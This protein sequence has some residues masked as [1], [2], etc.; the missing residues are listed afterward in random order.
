MANKISTPVGIA[1]GDESLSKNFEFD[2]LSEW[3]GYVSSVDKTNV[4]ENVMVQGSQ[5]IYKKLSGNLAV[6]PG[7]LRI[8]AANSTLSPVSSEYVWY[9]SWGA[10][11]PVW[12][13]NGELQ[14]SVKNVWYT[15]MSVVKTRYVFDK[16][17]N[18]DTATDELLFVCGDPNIYSWPGGVATLASIST[19]SGIVAVLAAAPT[20]GGSG[21]TVGDVLTITTGGSGAT[22]TVLTL[23]NGVITSV[24][25]DNAGTGYRVN[26]TLV[27]PGN[28]TGVNATIVVTSI[29]GGGSTGPITGISIQTP[30]G[31][32][33]GN[34]TNVG[35]LG[36]SGSNATINY[37]V[38]SA[39]IATVELTT[40]GSGYTTG[41]GKSTS[42]G[43]GSSA[44]LDIT[45]I[46]TGL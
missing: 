19:A 1:K 25:I 39:A 8:G 17:Y 34:E 38:T 22:A 10:T 28:L 35:V 20:N 9:T 29:S 33:G 31:T 26:D 24:T 16:W 42:G 43:T 6:R 14:V 32:Y 15:L 18:A 27:I 37:N 45:T 3:K 21:Y 23:S 36:G 5:N 11:Y 2:I 44:T 4:V 12:V 13:T 41:T 30:G 40:G 7:Q 46:A